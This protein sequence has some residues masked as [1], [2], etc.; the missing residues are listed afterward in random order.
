MVEQIEKSEN[1]ESGKLAEGHYD[2]ETALIDSQKQLGAYPEEEKALTLTSDAEVAGL[3]VIGA[4]LNN[5]TVQ[6]LTTVRVQFAAEVDRLALSAAAELQRGDVPKL[7]QL[8]LELDLGHVTASAVLPA[9][10]L[11]HGMGEAGVP[12]ITLQ[13]NEGS[14]TGSFTFKPESGGI[15][16]F[17]GE[18]STKFAAFTFEGTQSGTEQ[19]KVTALALEAP[20]DF[21]KAGTLTLGA[22]ADLTS[23]E[24][25]MS[26]RYTLTF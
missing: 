20:I 21:K 8:D 22:G 9:Q 1:A 16:I 15:R 5:A 17:S 23:N 11:F 25:T 19:V 7:E 14:V 12:E 2:L 6:R 24:R 3:N 26:A 10:T 13:L 18:L 4:A